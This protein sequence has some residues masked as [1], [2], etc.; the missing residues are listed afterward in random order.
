MHISN[1]FVH[2]QLCMNA[3]FYPNYFSTK[4][5]YFVFPCSL[6]W[7]ID[8]VEHPCGLSYRCELLGGWR[9]TFANFRST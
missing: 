4:D 9:S 5:D 3:Y 2:A 1:I 8:E 6:T 7:T